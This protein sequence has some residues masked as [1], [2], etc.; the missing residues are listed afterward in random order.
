MHYLVC[1]HSGRKAEMADTYRKITDLIK[2]HPDYFTP[3]D[4]LLVKTHTPFVL[5]IN[6]RV[7]AWK[8]RFKRKSLA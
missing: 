1:F 3:D 7:Q 5:S 6:S 8:G 2:N 4:L